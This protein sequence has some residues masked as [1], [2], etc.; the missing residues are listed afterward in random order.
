[1]E[2]S[3]AA[4]SPPLWVLSS[5]AT[6]AAGMLSSCAVLLPHSRGGSLA[7]A[8]AEPAEPI[9]GRPTDS[10]L[11]ALTSAGTNRRR[12]AASVLR[13]A[14]F[15]RASIV[16]VKPPVRLPGRS[17]ELVRVCATSCCVVSDTLRHF[18]NS[19]PTNSL[20]DI[21]GAISPNPGFAPSIFSACRRRPVRPPGS[22]A[23]PILPLTV[24]N[25]SM[26]GYGTPSAARHTT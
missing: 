5:L 26:S 21:S 25:A 8:A 16:T 2:C 1:M 19:R 6:T 9:S 11:P 15:E 23:G 10:R 22:R 14:L 24:E 7:A 18:S 12:S 3:A 17:G 20:C 4:D 13:I